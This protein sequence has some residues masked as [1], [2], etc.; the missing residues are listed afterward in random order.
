MNTLEMRRNL[1][2]APR[3]DIRPLVPVTGQRHQSV[4]GLCR[5]RRHQES[6]DSVYTTGEALETI[7]NTLETRRKLFYIDIKPLIL[8]TS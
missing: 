2:Y 8:A 7:I 5:P 3:F 6:T 1:L 4:C